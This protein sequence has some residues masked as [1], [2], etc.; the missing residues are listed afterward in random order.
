MP[1]CLGGLSRVG[2]SSR[3]TRPWNGQPPSINK[4]GLYRIHLARILYRRHPYSYVEPSSCHD[5]RDSLSATASHWACCIRPLSCVSFFFFFF[6]L[7]YQVTSLSLMLFIG[8]AFFVAWNFSTPTAL[9][10]T[11]DKRSHQNLTN[12]IGVNIRERKNG[13]KRIKKAG[14]HATKF[15]P[16][17]HL[18][19]SFTAKVRNWYCSTSSRH[20]RDL[21][22]AKTTRDIFN[23]G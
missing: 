23:P 12:I 14:N 9:G 11:D 3:S 6:Y 1:D 15:P 8:A 4:D 7:T 5:S 16:K 19:F 18:V 20:Y 21:T 17:R 22:P 10:R 2:I 13:T